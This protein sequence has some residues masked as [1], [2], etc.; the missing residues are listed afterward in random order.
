MTR[1]TDIRKIAFIGNY[2]PRKCGIATFTHDVC[3]SVATQ[4]PGSECFVVPVNDIA[5]G[6]DYPSEVRFEIE[7]QELES[8]LRA[9][10]YLNFSNADIVCLQ[11][12]YGIFGGPAGSHVIRLLRN[13]RMPIVTT[14]HTVLKEPSPDQRR[15]L[16]Q[17]IDLSARVIVM[18]E[19][20]RVFLREIYDVPESKIDVIAHG[21]PD[22]PF[23]DPAFYKD[24]FG[25]E[26]KFVA[27]TFGLLSP[28]KGIEHMLRA[29]P[30]ILKEFPNFV[31]IVLGATHPNLIREQGERYRISL[32]RL[33]KSLGIKS[34][35]S[36]YNRFV[37]IDEL[38]E[39]LG[40]ADIY[41]TPYLNP[42]QIT[43]GTLAYAFGCGKAVISTP[44]WH[45]EELLAE[46]RGVLV[47]FG[48]SAALTSEICDLLRDETRRHAMRKKGYMLGREMI[49]SHVSHHY[50][51]S[52]QRARRSRLDVP[53][54]PLAV[55]TLAEEPMDLPGW[56]LDHLIR[57]SD[58][59]GMLQ[60]AS[61]T[62]PNF[63]EGYCTDDNARALLLTLRLEQLGV[64]SAQIH[65]LTS[66]YSAFLNYA[67]DRKRNRFHNFMSFHRTWLEEVGSEDSQ[68]RALWALG[69]CVHL[70]RRKDL[71]FWASALFDLALPGLLETRS[72]RTW[73]FAILGI[74]HYL[75]RLSG[76]RQASQVR[77]TLTDRLIE[78]FDRTAAEGDDWLWFEDILAYDN[79]RLS[80]AL[81]VS[82]R[83]SGDSRALDIGLKSLGWLVGQQ[84]APAGHFRPIGSF[85]F[86]PR[87]Q[88]RAQ[89]DQQP[90]EACATVSACLAAY[91]A[92]D[93]T[94]WL[95]EARIAFEWFLGSNDLGLEL[96][97]S[98]T[99]GC[100]DGLQEDRVNQN[101][102][103]ESTLSFLLALGEMKLMESVLAFRQVQ[104][105]WP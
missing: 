80:Q 14:L 19:R 18:T 3:T 5:E 92:T 58:S 10:D 37:E 69:A 45:A 33:A 72:P 53:I 73:A 2:L 70:S 15:V 68:G 13:L 38:L 67:F 87:G 32:E 1:N 28:N 77:D 86:H 99:G 7:E 44:Y 78:C 16:D 104:A 8:Y 97:D 25:V 29:M 41:I 50:M 17:I 61:Y 46:G 85:G 62:I 105:T 9:A 95:K 35:V 24:Q 27:L 83:S 47:P 66:T 22:M 21:I 12:E 4:F 76:A 43:S 102:G 20:P 40:V 91:Q 81:I 30:A 63:D 96:Y 100:C 82:G 90:V 23:V 42:A 26:G 89:F 64:S 71:Q 52:F 31:Y 39:F 79:A 74:C 56:R 54:R 94:L 84:R 11:H 93:D 59:A 57:L 34:N 60:H 65:R 55:R 88:E 49:W 48:D 36:F 75:E 98:K 51:D 103:A 101:Q 6:Y